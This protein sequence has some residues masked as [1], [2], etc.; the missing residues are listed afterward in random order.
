MGKG[1]IRTKRGKIFNHSYGKYRKWNSK[2]ILLK[3]VETQNPQI[4]SRS[5]SISLNQK[6]N[7]MSILIDK[8]RIKNFRSLKNV[9]V[10]LQPVTLLVGANNAGKTTFLRALNIVFG[11]NKT[12]ITR[13][14]LFIDKDSKQPEKSIII[15]IRIVPVDEKGKRVNEF[16]EQWLRTFNNRTNDST[17]ELFAFRTEILFKK[18]GDKYD[19]NQYSLL[20]WGNP[21]PQVGEELNN[22]NAFKAVLLYFIDA[23]RDLTD[24]TRLRTS[25]FGKLATQLDDDYEDGDVKEITDLVKLLNDKAVEKSTVLRHL[26]TKLSELNQTT[27]TRGEGVSISP[28]PKKIRDLH[29]GMKVDYQ[30]SGSDTFSMEYHGMGTRS[31]ASILSFGAFSSWESDIKAAKSEQYFPILALEEP[32]AHLHPNAQRT[33]Y[34]QLKSMD[35]QKIISTHSPYIAGQAELEELRHFYKAEDNVQVGQLLFS[36]NDEIRVGEL[37]KEIEEKGN[38]RDINLQNRPVI[39]H[40]LSEKR[41]KLDG[42]EVRKIRREVMNTRGELLFSKAVI[43]FEGETEEQALPIL[44]K[45]YFKG[46]YPYELGLNFIGV[47]GKGNY[48]PFLNI[49]KFLNIPWYI[50]SDGDGSTESEVKAQI[51]GVFGNIYTTLFVLDSNA[52]F[53]KY[54][55]DNSFKNEL[56]KAINL[57]EGDN[58]FPQVYVDEQHGQKRKGAE[59]KIYKDAEGKIKEDAKDIA[60]LDCL[61]EGKTKYAE[62]I[63]LEIISKKDER[64]N[65]I[66]PPKISDLFKKIND[67]FIFNKIEIDETGTV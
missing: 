12:Q 34:R 18:E 47:G 15:D 58:Y 54:L 7:N 23:Q 53:E 24:D 25:Y 27:Q 29:K 21:E 13:D 48:Q 55:V 8:V 52:D 39:A 35:G 63:A 41:K 6:S 45:E 46:R 62:S 4:L 26:K 59:E 28:F 38:T 43:L 61:R 37:L 50:L 51:N 65:C 31:W 30:D 36:H 32:E 57:I 2:K 20:E 1:D 17:G 10:N 66:I 64:G 42:D 11:V 9:E 5:N 40:L 44:A 16:E 49:A 22:S 60:L 14:D 67:D 19:C 3:L 33:L 56:I